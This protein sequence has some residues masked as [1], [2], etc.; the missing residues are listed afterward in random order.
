MPCNAWNHSATCECGWGGQWHGNYGGRRATQSWTDEQIRFRDY[1]HQ[2]WVLG[3]LRRIAT[4]VNPN[5]TCPVCGDKVF[6]YQSPYGGRV[7]F[8]ELGP[9]WPKHPCTDNSS[10]MFGRSGCRD[11]P[12]PYMPSFSSEPAKPKWSKVGWDPATLVSAVV[13][14][15]GFTVLIVRRIENDDQLV[16]GINQSL[17]VEEVSP[18]F[19]QEHSDDLGVFDVSILELTSQDTSPTQVRAFRNAR[20]ASDAQDW[21]QALSGSAEHQNVVALKLLLENDEPTAPVVRV[22]SEQIDMGAVTLWLQRAV[23]AGSANAELNMRTLDA[24]RLGAR[25]GGSDQITRS[26]FQT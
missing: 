5:A 22:L 26:D 19:I 25:F 20:C 1:F 7:F 15:G 14:E 8:D 12:K 17:S 18:I 9:P 3:R 6:F 23:E 21:I 10:P 11:Y 13:L 16:L 2:Y 24:K 4:Y